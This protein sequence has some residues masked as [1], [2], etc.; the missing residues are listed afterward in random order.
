MKYFFED[1]I[2]Y[3]VLYSIFAIAAVIIHSCISVWDLIVF[4]FTHKKKKD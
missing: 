3:P 2:L 4:A 1:Y